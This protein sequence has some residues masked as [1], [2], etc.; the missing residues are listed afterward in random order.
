MVTLRSRLFRSKGQLCLVICQL[1]LSPLLPGTRLEWHLLLYPHFGS[2][3]DNR[4]WFL[5]F[6]PGTAQGHSG[7]HFSGSKLAQL[8]ASFDFLAHPYFAGAIHLTQSVQIV[9]PSLSPSRCITWYCLDWWC[10]FPGLGFLHWLDSAR[11]W[12]I[13]EHVVNF[14]LVS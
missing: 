3:A 13:P 2:Q 14:V 6:L 1:H 12:P 5:R 9:L 7:F 8:V 10:L 11:V 4:E